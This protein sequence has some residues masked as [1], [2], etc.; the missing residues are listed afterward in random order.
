MNAVER[1]LDRVEVT[2]AELVERIDRLCDR[3]DA[4]CQPYYE[5]RSK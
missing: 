4:M 3:L 5:T 2:L 1:R